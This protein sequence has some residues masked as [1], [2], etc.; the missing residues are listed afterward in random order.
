[1]SFHETKISTTDPVSSF[2]KKSVKNKQKQQQLQQQKQKQDKAR[3]L[4]LNRKDKRMFRVATDRSWVCEGR[5]GGVVQRRIYGWLVK[6][7]LRPRPASAESVCVFRG[8]S[9]GRG[10][11]KQHPSTELCGRRSRQVQCN[12]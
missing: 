4:P 9:E 8:A 2:V 10:S 1:M 7:K 3:C 11:K 5:G 12:A 6:L